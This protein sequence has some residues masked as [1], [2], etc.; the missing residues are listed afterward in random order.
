[1][2]TTVTSHVRN[3]SRFS[4]SLRIKFYR[5]IFKTLIFSLRK[6]KA[7]GQ[8]NV[9]QAFLP[10]YKWFREIQTKFLIGKLTITILASVK[11]ST[12]SRVRSSTFQ[13]DKLAE[14][15]Y[16]NKGRPVE[17]TRILFNEKYWPSEKQFSFV[18]KQNK[19][20]FS[21]KF[22]EPPSK[23]PSWKCFKKQW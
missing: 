8:S 14:S 5:L 13:K 7:F 2:F 3:I 22:S 23:R 18:N 9:L 16:R 6:W 15:L 17:I 11:N 21:N 20:E 1:M 10:S 12:I 19:F 4:V